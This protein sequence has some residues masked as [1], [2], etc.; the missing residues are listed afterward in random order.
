MNNKNKAPVLAKVIKVV[1]DKM[2]KISYGSASGWGTY[3][4][5][6]PVKKK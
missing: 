2:A 3:Q 1:A 5:K 6:E 4:P